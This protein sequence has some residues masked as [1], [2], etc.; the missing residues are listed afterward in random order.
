MIT[1]SFVGYYVLKI[2]LLKHAPICFK[3]KKIKVA[4]FVGVLYEFCENCWEIVGLRMVGLENDWEMVDAE[5]SLIRSISV[6]NSDQRTAGPLL[7]LCWKM[8][9]CRMVN[10]TGHLYLWAIVE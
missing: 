9:V 5:I 4:L 7:S 6:R 2:A 10:Q 1:D 8:V 3:E